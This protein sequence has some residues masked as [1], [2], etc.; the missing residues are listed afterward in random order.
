MPSNIIT[1]SKNAK[2]VV[3]N[4]NSKVNVFVNAICLDE[5]MNS[6]PNMPEICPNGVFCIDQIVSTGGAS[7]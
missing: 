3:N 6:C 2:M 4:L 1:F 7:G 5:A